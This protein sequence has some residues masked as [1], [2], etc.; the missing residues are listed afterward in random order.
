MNMFDV[1]LLD[2]C[3]AQGKSIV[4]SRLPLKSGVS[5]LALPPRDALRSFPSCDHES[6]RTVIVPELVTNESG[7]CRLRWGGPA[8][9]PEGPVSFC[10][11][12]L[13]YKDVNGGWHGYSEVSE[14]LLH[15]PVDA[16][17]FVQALEK[18]ASV[19]DDDI[20]MLED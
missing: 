14:F 7:K 9:H 19:I 5:Y 20:V 15:S 12:C 11:K 8:E 1:V 18:G 17:A 16:E 3:A 2:L 4:E 13:A 6:V 10:R